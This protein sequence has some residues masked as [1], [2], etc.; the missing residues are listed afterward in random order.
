MK[1]KLALLTENSLFFIFEDD[2]EKLP[3]YYE[4]DT[5]SIAYMCGIT[6]VVQYTDFEALIE[7]VEQ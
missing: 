2:T 6:C 3:F 4:D 7:V 5:T 1:E